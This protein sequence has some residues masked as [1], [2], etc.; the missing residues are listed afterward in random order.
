MAADMTEEAGSG[1]QE[2]R[3]EK[4]VMVT[5]GDAKFVKRLRCKTTKIIEP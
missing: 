4:D 2:S 1:G 5:S 3:R